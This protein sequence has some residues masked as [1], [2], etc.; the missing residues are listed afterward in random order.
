MIFCALLMASMVNPCGDDRKS[1]AKGACLR[2]MKLFVVQNSMVVLAA[3][4]A[5]ISMGLGLMYIK[6]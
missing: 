4:L 5:P 6:R 1:K 3:I 2:W